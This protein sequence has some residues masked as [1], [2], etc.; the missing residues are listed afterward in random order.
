MKYHV[1]A[2]INDNKHFSEI[3]ANSIEE[4]KKKALKFRGIFH[5]IKFLWSARLHV[6]EAK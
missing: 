1:Y 5:L 2:T 4:A 6:E 3:E